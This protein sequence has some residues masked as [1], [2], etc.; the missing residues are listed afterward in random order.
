MTCRA[1]SLL[2]SIMR[3]EAD[4][5]DAADM[6]ALAPQASAALDLDPLTHPQL[7]FVMNDQRQC[8]HHDDSDDDGEAWSTPPYSLDMSLVDEIREWESALYAK[9]DASQTEART[10]VLIAPRSWS[11]S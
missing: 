7:S 10:A 2:R 6:L 5:D 11:A 3:G 8:K 4:G 1:T 9:D